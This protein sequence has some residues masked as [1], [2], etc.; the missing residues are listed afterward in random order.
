MAT[1]PLEGPTTV[2][3]EEDIIGFC[4]ICGVK[5]T[6]RKKAIGV[7]CDGES[8]IVCSYECK[9]KWRKKFGPKDLWDHLTEE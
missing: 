4:D 3:P 8:A 9:V 7:A 6:S 2:F 1:Y 5:I